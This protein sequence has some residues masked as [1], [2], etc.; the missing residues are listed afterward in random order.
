MEGQ[1][2]SWGILLTSTHELRKIPQTGRG[3][4]SADVDSFKGVCFKEKIK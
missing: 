2:H 3:Y 1:A 4:G